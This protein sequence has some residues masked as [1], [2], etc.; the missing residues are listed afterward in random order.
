MT[1]LPAPIRAFI[2][3]TNSADSDA[4]VAVFT[5][6]AYLE[7]WGRVFRGHDGA[8]S[9]NASDNIGKRSHFVVDR[10]E[11]DGDDWIV[12]VTV[13]GDGFNGTSP[14][15]FTVDGDRISRMVIAP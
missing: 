13:T 2:D 1:D 14:I 8:R 15:R 10:A 4:F 7:D 3:T 6:D 5:D 9:W 11:R 12:T